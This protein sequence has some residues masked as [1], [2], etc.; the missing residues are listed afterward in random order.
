MN[1]LKIPP[2]AK[3]LHAGAVDRLRLILNR[4]RVCPAFIGLSAIRVRTALAAG[5]HRTSN[6]RGP[7]TAD[8]LLKHIT[9]AF[10]FVFHTGYAW[11]RSI[12]S[13]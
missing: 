5:T 1:L 12:A 9:T 13:G 3:S 11:A 8:A 2:T 4:I 7:G 10:P 6:T